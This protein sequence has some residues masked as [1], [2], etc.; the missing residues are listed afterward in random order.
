LSTK[1]KKRKKER[2][3]GRTEGAEGDCNLI[4]RTTISTN[5]T[6]QS[7]LGLN[8]QPKSINGGCHGS[9][10]ICRR[11]L[12]YLASMG[13]EIRGPMQDLCPSLQGYSKVR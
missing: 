10:F 4:R 12:P 11:G 2:V 13:G 5:W 9:S 8:H 3:S 1:K 7:S 6:T